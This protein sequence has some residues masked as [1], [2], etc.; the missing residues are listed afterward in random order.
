[1]LFWKHRAYLHF[2]PV[3][4]IKGSSEQSFCAVNQKNRSATQWLPHHLLVYGFHF[5][6]GFMNKLLRIL[7]TTS[8]PPNTK[9]DDIQITLVSKLYPKI[10]NFLIYTHSQCSKFVVGRSKIQMNF[11]KIDDIDKKGKNFLRFP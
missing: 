3:E 9:L 10:F 8:F 2:E 4:V 6:F 7:L 11:K 1:M 5:V